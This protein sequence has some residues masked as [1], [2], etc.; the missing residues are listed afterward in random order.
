MHHIISYSGGV[1]SALTAQTVMKHFP[2][3]TVELLF[4]DTLVEDSDLYRF[5]RDIEKLLDKKITV[6]ADGRT[7]WKVFEDVKYVGNTRVDPCSMHLKRIL[8]RKYL[9]NNHTP[10]SVVVWAGIDLLEE[11]RLEPMV[12][13][14]KPYRYR[15]ILIENNV[16]LSDA[17]KKLWCQE[18]GIEPPR[19]YEMGFSHNNCGGFC[20]KAGLAHFKNLWEKLPEVYLDNE[21]QQEEAIQRN[22]KLRPFL[23]KTI[24]GKLAYLTMKQYRENYLTKSVELTEDERLEFG[25]CGCVA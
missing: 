2:G 8:I 22:P 14:N 13:R 3:D 23:R 21:R 24:D 7:P 15:S 11:H 4:A 25:G 20:V 12:T 1:G 5:N 18:N 16:M 17:L 9:R 19:L 6:I 10:E